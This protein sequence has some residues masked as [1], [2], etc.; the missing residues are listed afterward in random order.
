[1][2]VKIN[3]LQFNITQTT[4]ESTLAT[5]SGNVLFGFT[6]YLAQSIVL[7][8]NTSKT[9]LYATLVHELTHAFIFAYGYSSQETF[10]HEQICEFVGT[11]ASDIIKIADKYIKGC[12]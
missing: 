7:R 3:K 1:M 11:Y 8:A 9:M 6:D 5:K 2:R 10:N 4:D 12:K